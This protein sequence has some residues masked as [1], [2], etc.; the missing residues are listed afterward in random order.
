MSQSGTEPAKEEHQPFIIN[1]GSENAVAPEFL[2][3][4]GHTISFKLGPNPNIP[5]GSKVRVKFHD[6]K[7]FSDKDTFTEGETPVRVY[8]TLPL[9]LTTGFDCEVIPPSRAIRGG[10]IIIGR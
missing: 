7:L 6:R 3:T 4:N 9:P 8:T 2:V 10:S 5:A 1:Y